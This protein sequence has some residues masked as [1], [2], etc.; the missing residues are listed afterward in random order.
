MK[1]QIKEANIRKNDVLFGRGSNLN[2]H[3]K[4]TVWREY[5]DNEGFKSCYQLHPFKDKYAKYLLQLVRAH[6]RPASRFLVRIDDTSCWY[7][8]EEEEI[9]EKTKRKLREPIVQGSNQVGNHTANEHVPNPPPD[10]LA[11]FN[12][13][14]LVANAAPIIQIN[15]A[16]SDAECIT[17][18]V[19]QQILQLRNDIQKLRQ[20][21]QESTAHF[22]E[23]IGSIMTLLTHIQASL[24]QQPS[25]HSD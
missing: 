20:E 5:V 23:A 9:I 13:V 1:R 12:H 8:A 4:D 3:N 16:G 14:H 15:E 7:E 18:P 2:L 10:E 24:P 22:T 25:N 21:F 11:P 6:S 19:N 17:I